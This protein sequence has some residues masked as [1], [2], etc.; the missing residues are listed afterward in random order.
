ME[1]IAIT[2]PRMSSRTQLCNRILLP[3]ATRMTAKPSSIRI[4][5]AN[6]AIPLLPN[7]TSAAP[8]SSAARPTRRA[9]PS[10]ESRLARNTLA[11][12]APA[13]ALLTSRPKVRASPPSTTFA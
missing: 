8:A 7:A 10:I 3:A 5:Y 2:R 4:G 1:K 9:R 11:I 6:Q 12:R 13:P